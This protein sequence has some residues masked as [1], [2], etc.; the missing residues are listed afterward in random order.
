MQAER[1]R[2][3]GQLL[4]LRES[5]ARALEEAAAQARLCWLCFLAV[6]V[7]CAW[8]ARLVFAASLC[9]AHS[10][11]MSLRSLRVCWPCFCAVSLGPRLVLLQGCVMRHATG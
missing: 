11:G 2:H 3:S 10:H 8:C 7:R 6:F 4:Q 1:E 5:S 9:H